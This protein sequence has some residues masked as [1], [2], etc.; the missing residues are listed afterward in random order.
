M[1]CGALRNA[2]TNEELEGGEALD[3]F[4]A[5]TLGWVGT[6]GMF[7]AYVLIWRGWAESTAIHYSLLNAVGGFMA[8]A[9]ALAYGAWPAFSSSLVWGLIGALGLVAAFRAKVAKRASGAH[10]KAQ[11]QPADRAARP[12]VLGDWDPSRTE[13]SPIALPWLVRSA[14]TGMQLS[15]EAV[16]AAA[17]R[18]YA[19]SGDVSGPHLSVPPTQTIQ[20]AC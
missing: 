5:V 20:I 3:D 17:H 7:A 18:D 15:R 4:I 14:D 1:A 16:P 6:V 12:A 13:A 2:G 10:A 11:A 9:G 8:A 19:T